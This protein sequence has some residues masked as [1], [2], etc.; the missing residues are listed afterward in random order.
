MR[1]DQGRRPTPTGVNMP[2][3][4]LLRQA[5]RHVPRSLPVALSL[6]LLGCS[7]PAPAPSPPKALTEKVP[8][9]FRQVELFK[10][11]ET[12]ISIPRGWW[13][14]FGDEALNDLQTRLIADNPNLLASL[15]QIRIAQAALDSSRAPLSP[16]VGTALSVTRSE[17]QQASSS[18]TAL[19][20][21]LSASWEADLWGRLG[22][23]IDAAAAR[24]QASEFDLE[25][26]RLSL[27]ASLT[28]TWLALRAAQ[29][30]GALLETTVEAYTRSLQMTED[31]YRVG[32]VPA[33]DVAQAQT[34]LKTAQAQAAELQGTRAVLENAIAVLTGQPPAA[35]ATLAAKGLPE[36]P[37]VPLQLP[38][39]LL[40]RRPDVAA[41]ERRVVAA[42]AQ[43]GVAR[44]A[45]FPAV[46]LSAN[47]SLRSRNLADLF[48]APPL[49]WSLGPGLAIAALDGGAR[50]AG[51]ESARASLELASAQ[52][53]QVILTAMQEVEDNLALIAALNRQTQLLE[54]S[55]IQ[56][57]RALELTLNQYRAGT[58]SY[59]NVVAAQTTALSVERS[60]LDARSRR[61]NASNLLLKN[62]AGGWGRAQLPPAATG[63]PAAT[64]AA[65]LQPAPAR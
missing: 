55:L 58:V 5:S 25:G 12:R 26:L 37:E 15:A 54:E 8:A 40:R 51:L 52:Y 62:L 23:Q 11:T 31:R 35:L 42:A 17:S 60:L 13:Q 32:I 61:L 1:A 64:P 46:T 27:Q 59:L 16:T 43:L 45:F 18:G 38:A 22:S 34:Q 30:Q 63:A 21:A 57:R 29:A 48:A 28:Q 19:V 44:A 39:E 7:A 3:A 2:I 50:Q 56:A 10:A 65:P 33:T 47:A 53:R 41:A 6:A 24:L 14:L 4:R 49:L 9:E 36:A 20:P